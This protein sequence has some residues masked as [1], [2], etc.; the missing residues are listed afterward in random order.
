MV[1]SG[2]G[3]HADVSGWLGQRAGGPFV[4]SR[5]GLSDSGSVR[6][7]KPERVAESTPVAFRART[8][9]AVRI[10]PADRTSRTELMVCGGRWQQKVSG[11][12]QAAMVARSMHPLKS[13]V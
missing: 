7:A 9:V 10:G 6:H 8:L 13:V 4:C 2:G 1:E 3:T 5:P 11:G 12:L